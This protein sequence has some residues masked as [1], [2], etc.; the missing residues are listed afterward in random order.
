MNRAKL[1]FLDRYAVE[2]QHYDRKKIIHH[3]IV[4]PADTDDSDWGN[5]VFLRNR[6][7]LEKE[8]HLPLMRRSDNMHIRGASLRHHTTT[9]NDIMDALNHP[10]GHRVFNTAVT[11]HNLPQEGIDKIV[12]S[13]DDF[14]KV[15]AINHPNNTKA[16]EHITS[17]KDNPKIVHSLVSDTDTPSHLLTHVHNVAKL[18]EED[19]MN[20]VQHPNVTPEI[21]D[22][23]YAKNGPR[24]S[25]TLKMIAH[26]KSPE[27]I[28]K[29]MNDVNGSDNKL[30]Q[31]L[32]HKELVYNHHAPAKHLVAAVDNPYI[33]K[34]EREIGNSAVK[35]LAITIGHRNER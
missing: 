33:S 8:E 11:L 32:A 30:M 10:H 21:H 2:G 5:Y 13:D 24:H 34:E 15:R 14:S 7:E 6:G 31:T 1:K 18:H 23:I 27:F 9:P 25:T 3:M 12:A 17:L 16:I 29:V 4:S 26:S 35:R 19:E 28:D 22:A 20:L